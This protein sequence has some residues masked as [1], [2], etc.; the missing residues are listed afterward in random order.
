[1]GQLREYIKMA[2]KNIRSNKG[3]SILTMLGI[4]IGIASV[5]LIIS[6]GNGVKS[7]VGDELNSLGGGQLYLYIAGDCKDDEWLNMD[8]IYALQEKVDHLRG[9]TM[10]LSSDSSKVRAGVKVRDASVEAGTQDFEFVETEKIIKGKYFDE[11]DVSVGRRVCVISKQSALSLFGTTN[12]IG[13]P[14]EITSNGRTQDFTICGLRDDKQ[15]SLLSFAFGG[16]ERIT[17]E[18]PYTAFGSAFGYWTDDFYSLYLIADSSAHSGQIAKE[19][20]NLIEGRKN[21][22]G[23]G[24]F[25]IENFQDTM[26]G[27]DQIMGYIT[28]F[29]VFVAA[30]SLLVGGIGVMNIMLVSVTERTREI[31]I[32]KALGAKTR[33]ILTQ[34]LAEAMIITALGGLIGIGIGLGGAFAAG[35]VASVKISVDPVVVIGA[36]LFSSGIGIIF[37][38]YPAR[39]A[40]RL[41]PIEALRH[42]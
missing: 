8:D 38:V 2:L 15:V 14:L 17:I 23:E 35:A 4:I 19:A 21:L 3:R 22:R 7:S 24:V 16:N 32:R 41:S 9:V 6:I 18:I 5:I 31:G 11:A 1:M 39:K 36:T 30:I 33:S 26:D 20:I 12:V 28:I 37:G 10:Y 40:A 42:E 25:A 34:F 27:F 13:M 29:T